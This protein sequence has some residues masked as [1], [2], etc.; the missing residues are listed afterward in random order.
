MNAHATKFTRNGKDDA[1]SCKIGDGSCSIKDFNA[2]PC[3][4]CLIS[5]MIMTGALI[6]LCIK[7]LMNYY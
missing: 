3:L 4:P 7:A 1:H 2:K 5:R 6:F